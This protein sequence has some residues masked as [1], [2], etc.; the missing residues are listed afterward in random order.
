MS[1]DPKFDGEKK[2]DEQNSNCT[3]PIAMT[4]IEWFDD[5][6]FFSY[7]EI[8]FEDKYLF[9]FEWFQQSRGG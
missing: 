7:H 6:Y 8:Y 5:L 1:R 3:L 4:A 9:I 2:T